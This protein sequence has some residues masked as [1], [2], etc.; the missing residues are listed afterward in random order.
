M[1]GCVYPQ[2]AAGSCRLPASHSAALLEQLSLPFLPAL[3]NAPQLQVTNLVAKDCFIYAER[4][5]HCTNKTLSVLRVLLEKAELCACF[6]K[7]SPQPNKAACIHTGT[8]RN[9]RAL[10]LLD[11]H[12]PWGGPE[13]NLSPSLLLLK[14]DRFLMRF[15]SHCQHS[16]VNH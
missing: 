6:L 4:C 16:K 3:C 7:P 2:D 15:A 14:N 10:E 8:G 5:L 1:S 9:P 13:A 12:V 11:C